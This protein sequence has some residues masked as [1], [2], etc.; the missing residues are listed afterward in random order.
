MRFGQTEVLIRHSF[1]PIRVT[2]PHIQTDLSSSGTRKTAC[3]SL[4]KTLLSV[5]RMILTVAAE[6]VLWIE[7][8]GQ[9][10][11]Q[12]A[13]RGCREL[14]LHLEDDVE[15]SSGCAHPFKIDSVPTFVLKKIL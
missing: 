11:H 2:K 12:L 5:E 15:H 4:S 8:V 6:A 7:D 1:W 13:Y 14:S 9:S 3:H 10:R